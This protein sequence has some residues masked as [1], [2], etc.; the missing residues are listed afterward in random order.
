MLNIL[1]EIQFS[2]FCGPFLC[3]NLDR[4]KHV[5]DK[6]SEVKTLKIRNTLDETAKNVQS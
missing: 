6:L 2:K 1:S 4:K 5:S 3:S